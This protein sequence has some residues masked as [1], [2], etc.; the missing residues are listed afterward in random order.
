[1]LPY[2]DPGRPDLRSPGR[3]L[4]WI[5]R[6]QASSLLVGMTWGTLWFVAQALLPVTIGTAID[7]G[8]VAHDGTA[9]LEW[10][11][12]VLGLAVVVSFCGI[13]RHRAAVANWLQA[14]F[15]MIQLLGRHTANVGS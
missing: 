8:V 11:G 15:R 7:K 4:W 3:L 6:L 5:A 14:A 10:S 12:A 9:L 13:M 1:S 2:P